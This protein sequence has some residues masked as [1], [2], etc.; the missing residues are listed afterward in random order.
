MINQFAELLRGFMM[1]NCCVVDDDADKIYK[2][3][4]FLE[5][6]LSHLERN[7]HTG[8][9]IYPGVIS[10]NTGVKIKKVYEILERMER[11][12][13]TKKCF[14]IHCADCNSLTGIVFDNYISIPEK[15]ICPH[16]KKEMDKAHEKAFVIYKML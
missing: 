8:D 6:I 14:E 4:G 12:G 15:A 5:S 3:I 13:K 9:L 11:T 10:L 2:E 7:H 1:E 16:C